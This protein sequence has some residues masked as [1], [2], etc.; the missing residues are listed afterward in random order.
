MAAK[1]ERLETRLS[2]D[3]RERIEQAASAAGVSVSAFVVGVAVER[4]DEI[5]AATTSTVV[6]ANYFD[7]L[8]AALDEPEPAPQL[9]KTAKRS[10]RTPRITAR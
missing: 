9:A 10:R 8:L 1:T 6:P 5:I 2:A 7:G 3:E 4:A